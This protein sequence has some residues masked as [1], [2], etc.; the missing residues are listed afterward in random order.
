MKYLVKKDKLKRNFFAKNELNKF[1]KENLFKNKKIYA[2]IR[3]KTFSAKRILTKTNIVNRC[4]FTGRK[5]GILSKFKL[6][7]LEF[8]RK[9]SKIGLSGFKL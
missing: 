4:V 5:H 1:I 2:S 3:W 6:S 9:G 8:F 7:R